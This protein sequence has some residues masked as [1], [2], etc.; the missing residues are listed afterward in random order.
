LPGFV[1]RSSEGTAYCSLPFF[2]PNGGVLCAQDSIMEDI[3]RALIGYVLDFMQNQP[4]ALTASIYTPF[5][6]ERFQCYDDLMPG[7]VVVPKTTLCLSLANNTLWDSKLRYDLR[8]AEKSDMTISTV[9]SPARVEFFYQIY[10]QN[11]R[12][13]G[14]PLKPW[15]TIEI[16]VE[17]GIPAKRVRCYFGFLDEKMVAGLMILFSPGTASYYIP[18]T[19]AEVRTIQ[20]GSALIDRAIRDARQMGIGC[21]NWES[22]PSPE[23]GVFHFKKKWG[24]Q[25]SEYRIYVRVFCDLE[26][27]R[28]LGAKGFSSNFPYFYIFPYDRL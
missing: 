11:C 18:C 12:E 17:K 13:Y 28:R 24:S 25:A 3:H 10:A 9:V 23:S 6:F 26:K 1:K 27:L 20:P 7:A 22:S 16:L 5:L 19:L 14:I 21:W 2:G 4:E 8:R 15:Q